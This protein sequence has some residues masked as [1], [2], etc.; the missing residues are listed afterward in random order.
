MLKPEFKV[1]VDPETV[2]Q[3]KTMIEKLLEVIRGLKERYGKKE[4]GTP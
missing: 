3:K 4:D 2:Q 1:G